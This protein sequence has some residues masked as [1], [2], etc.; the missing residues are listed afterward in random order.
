M[1]PKQDAATD[2]DDARQ[3]LQAALQQAWTFWTYFL[4]AKRKEIEASMRVTGMGAAGGT[5][6]AP[7]DEMDGT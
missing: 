3:R 1:S 6:A 4:V 7:K 5:A 2:Y